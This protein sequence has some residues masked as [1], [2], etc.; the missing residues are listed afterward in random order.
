MRDR[1]RSHLLA[2]KDWLAITFSVL[3]LLVSALSFYY[4]NIRIEDSATAGLTHVTTENEDIVAQVVFTNVGNRQASILEVHYQ[5]SAGDSNFSFG[6]LARST[7]FPLTLPPHELRIVDLRIPIQ[8]VADNYK[9]GAVI[10]SQSENLR[11]LVCI[12]DFVSLDSRGQIHR[13]SSTVLFT[14]EVSPKGLKSLSDVSEHSV[15]ALLR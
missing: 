14:V 7:S 5:F 13:T 11:R 10:D 12:F 2:L 15:T 4:S 8:Y 3:A 9:V 1:N 6:N